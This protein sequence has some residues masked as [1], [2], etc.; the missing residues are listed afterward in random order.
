LERVARVPEF[1]FLINNEEGSLTLGADLPFG[2]STEESLPLLSADAVDEDIT[3]GRS[4]L[5]GIGPPKVRAP[6][7]DDFSSPAQALGQPIDCRRCLSVDAEADDFRVTGKFHL[8]FLADG[9]AGLPAHRFR[10]H[11]KNIQDNGVS[12]IRKTQASVE[13]IKI[14][15]HFDPTD[16]EEGS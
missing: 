1:F 11:L 15:L 7:N 16:F 14:N 4:F 13:M 9:N 8:G 10:P 5:I 12:Q 3:V 6:K 2:D